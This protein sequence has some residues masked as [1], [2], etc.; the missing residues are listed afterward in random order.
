MSPAEYTKRKEQIAKRGQDI[1]K[2]EGAKEEIMKRLKADYKINT[3]AELQ[4]RSKEV[5]AEKTELS[6][7]REAL[8]AKLEALL[9][10]DKV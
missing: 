6:E 4:A 5:A 8:Y 9:D 2:A 10:W 3:V 7:T 1:T